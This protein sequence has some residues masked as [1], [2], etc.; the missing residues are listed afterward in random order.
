MRAYVAERGGSEERVRHGV[1]EGVAVGVRLEGGAA[2][3]RDAAEDESPVPGERVS[4]S[5]LS[6]AHTEKAFTIHKA[7]DL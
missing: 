4:L 2:L 1:R 7:A 3:E 5:A 6:L